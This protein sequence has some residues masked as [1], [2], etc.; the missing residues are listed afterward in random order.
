MRVVIGTPR[1][2]ALRC[3]EISTRSRFQASFQYLSTSEN[4]GGLQKDANDITGEL[5][6][7]DF[8]TQLT[9]YLGRSSFYP[10]TLPN[11]HYPG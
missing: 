6:S 3:T 1:R 7:G 4:R 5:F 11:K 8:L 2:V 10:L 9:S